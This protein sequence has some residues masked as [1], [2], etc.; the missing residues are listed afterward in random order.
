MNHVLYGLIAGHRYRR[1]LGRLFAESP[2]QGTTDVDLARLRQDGARALVFDFDGVLA[3]HAAEFPLEETRGVLAR[4]L[5]LFG[6]GH[7]YILSNK[8]SAARRDFFAQYFPGIAFIGGV[9]KK[10][11]PDGLQKVAELG[12][13]DPS[14]IVLLDDRLLTGGLASLLADTKF[15]YISRPYAD[16]SRNFLKEFFFAVLRRFEAAL[17]RWAV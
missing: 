9:R 2:V 7:V 3:P 15:S 11:Y 8:P 13:Y 4:A 14:A 17:A 12:G 16:F 6:S 1:Q 10:P 5:D